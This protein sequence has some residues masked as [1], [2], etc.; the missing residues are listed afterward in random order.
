MNVMK[1]KIL[2][3]D[4]IPQNLQLLG[5]ALRNKAYQ[6]FFAN[7]GQEALD[8][9]AEINFDLIL[10]DIMMPGMDGYTVCDR[11]KEN[12]ETAGVPIIFLTAKTDTDS[13]VKGFK[14]GAVDYI[15]K[16]FV[17]EE[18][19][20][21]ISTHL[22]IQAEINRRK[23]TQNKII[24]FANEMEQAKV[25]AEE[26]ADQLFDATIELTYAK[27]ELD[28]AN[29][30]K[31]TLL[32][33]I[34]HDLRG[35]VGNIFITLKML[36]DEVISP[37]DEKTLLVQLG[38][39]AE[40]TF[41]LLENLLAWASSQKGQIQ[42]IPKTI[43]LANLCNKAVSYQLASASA[44]S[45]DVDIQIPAESEVFADIQKGLSLRIRTAD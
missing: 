43:S 39:A 5:N 3:V 36:L 18:L 23:R 40:N 7:S 14:R 31:N 10:L 34:A 2:I 27:D 28:R 32:S 42:Y 6:V 11:L 15:S 26:N 8:T 17:V 4:D 25:C 22:T 21:R 33:I 37:A 12:D 13:I 29:Q 41:N 38:K 30:A 1:P 35:P 24:A 19:L 20:A 45:I 9:V 44:K 16:P